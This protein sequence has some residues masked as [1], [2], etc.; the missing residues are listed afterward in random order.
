[1]SR[2]LSLPYPYNQSCFDLKQNRERGGYVIYQFK[3]LSYLT[4]STLERWVYHTLLWIYRCLIVLGGSNARQGW[5]YYTT[6]MYWVQASSVSGHPGNV[7]CRRLPLQA[8]SAS[9]IALWIEGTASL[10][11]CLLP[12]ALLPAFLCHQLTTFPICAVYSHCH[13]PHPSCSSKIQFSV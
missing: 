13:L 3:V 6:R 8:R 11:R 9:C 7:G 2:I 5:C 4:V 1:M 12:S 10:P